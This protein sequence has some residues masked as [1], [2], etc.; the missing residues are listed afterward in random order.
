MRLFFTFCL[1]I[2]YSFTQAQRGNI[3]YFGKSAGLSFNTRPLTPLTD[4]Q[5]NSREGISTICDDN[6]RLL[7]YSNGETI[8]NSIHQEM[9]NGTNLKGHL[10]SCQAVLI[11]PKPG[12]KNLYYVFTSDALENDFLNGY[13]YHIVDMRLDGGLGA[14]V[15]KNNLLYAGSSERLTSVTAGDYKSY[16]V[17]TNEFN[18]N[19]FKAYKLDCSGLN[20]TPVVS[21]AGRKT[22]ESPYSNIGVMRVSPNGKFLIQTNLKGRGLRTVPSDEYAQLFD[23]N[24]TTGVISNP[25]LFPLFDEGYYFGAEFSPNS[26]F[27]YMV[28]PEKENVYQYDVSSANY[29]T[30]FGT[31]KIINVSRGELA[32]IA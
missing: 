5:V 4:G 32:A 30:I 10:S 7:F 28:N 18:S 11:L 27:L 17:I 6:G 25:R 14:V 12:D 16:W 13:N 29:A 24:N 8:F 19:V 22:D 2:T 9:M 23:F 26:Q 21:V 20:T 1:L 31:K 3:W 15:S